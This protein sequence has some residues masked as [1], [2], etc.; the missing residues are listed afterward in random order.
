MYGN[1][2]RNIFGRIL[3]NVTRLPRQCNWRIPNSTHCNVFKTRVEKGNISIFLCT[4]CNSVQNVL[5]LLRL[6]LV[7]SWKQC[8]TDNRRIT[9]KLIWSESYSAPHIL[10]TILVFWGIRTRLKPKKWGSA[11]KIYIGWCPSRS[12]RH[13]KFEVRWTFPLERPNGMNKHRSW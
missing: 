12:T 10:Y 13:K 6:F 7:R 8:W 5:L 2:W 3:D 1:K 4:W 9:A 11:L